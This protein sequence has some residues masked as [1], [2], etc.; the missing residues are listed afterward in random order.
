VLKSARTNVTVPNLLCLQTGGQWWQQQTHNIQY[1]HKFCCIEMITFDQDFLMQSSKWKFEFMQSETHIFFLGLI[2]F[3]L[4][5]NSDISTL[6]KVW[7]MH[8]FGVWFCAG[9]TVYETKCIHVDE[10]KHMLC[11]I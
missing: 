8:L 9:F 11:M 1:Y 3:R 4:T 2:H 7:F 6:L 10:L 5:K